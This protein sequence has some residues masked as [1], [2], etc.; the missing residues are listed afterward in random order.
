[1]ARADVRGSYGLSAQQ[2]TATKAEGNLK[3]KNIS[4]VSPRYHEHLAAYNPLTSQLNLLQDVLHRATS[5]KLVERAV[6]RGLRAPPVACRGEIKCGNDIEWTNLF[7]LLLR[8]RT[9][10]DTLQRGAPFPTPS[11]HRCCA[12]Y[13]G[14]ASAYL[15][16]AGCNFERWLAMKYG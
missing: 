2:W 4:I 8:L 11:R 16:D 9:G 12:K 15:F 10:A 1:M 13:E 7:A 6:M 5:N 3:K 14:E